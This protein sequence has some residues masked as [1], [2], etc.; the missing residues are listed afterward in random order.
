M[1]QQAPAEHHIRTG[2]GLTLCAAEYGTAAADRPTVVLLHGYPDTKEVWDAVARRLAPRFHVIA[3]DVRGH[4]RSRAP[5]PLRGGFTLEKLTEDFLAV[6][7]ALAPGRAVHLVGHDWGSVQGWEFTTAARTHGRIAG[8]TS[9]SGP[10]LD[11]LGRWL[12]R[13]ALHPTPRNLA[14]LLAQGARSW[15]I[16]LFQ[17]PLLPELAWRGPVGA[18]F[19]ALLRRMEHLPADGYPTGSLRRDAAHGLWLYRDNVRPRLRD[20]RPATRAHAPVQVIQ[21]TDDPYVSPR[22]HEGL[23]EWVPRLVRRSVPGGHWAPRSRPERI[24]RLVAGF[25]DEIEAENKA[26]AESK[27]ENKARTVAAAPARR[28]GNRWT[29][30]LGGQLVLVTGAAGGI[31]RATAHAFARAGA[32]VIA[33]DRD[34]EGAARTAAAARRLGA[35]DAWAHPVDV[36]DEAA[37]EKLAAEVAERHGAPDILVNNAGVGLAGPFLATTAEE[38]RRV[39][40]VNLWGV[41]HGCRLFGRQMAERGEGGHIVNVASLAAYQPSRST[42]AYSTS[43]AGVLMLSECLRGE[44]AEHGIGVSAVCPGI[45]RTGITR[46]TRFAGTDEAEEARRRE[47][48]SRLYERRNYPPEKVATAI[49]RAVLD[50]AA[51]VPVT[52][53]A[54]VLRV[55]GRVSPRARRALARIKPGS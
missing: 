15:Y 19:P 7:D 37:M 1:A 4:G 13:R 14:Q 35:P 8:F 30:R 46:T 54:R 27:A 9:L 28:A 18:V 53:E 47:E 42:P 33:V 29:E 49:L 21:P 17:L 5:R 10:C 40:D 20:P 6:T 48:V 32:R 52:T 55:L 45:V 36:G 11:H 38:W 44:L 2:D 39:L 34:G 22:L 24:A 16:G 41:I 50:N 43:K 12:R 23:E 3:Y 51:V 31:G 26:E 25:A